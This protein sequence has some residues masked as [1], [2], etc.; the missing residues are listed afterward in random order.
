P[1]DP[2]LAGVFGIPASFVATIAASLATPFPTRHERELIRDIR[3][4][5]G[6]ILYDREMRLLRLKKRQRAF[7]PV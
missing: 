6:E 4:P 3:V 5:G 1:L 7:D 2:A